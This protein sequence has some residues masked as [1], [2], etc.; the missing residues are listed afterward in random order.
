MGPLF[1]S[2]EPEQPNGTHAQETSGG[3]DGREFVGHA[4]ANGGGALTRRRRR[5]KVKEKSKNNY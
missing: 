2:A 4:T 3:R 1:S 5:R